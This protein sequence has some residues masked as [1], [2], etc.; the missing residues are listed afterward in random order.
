MAVFNQ[1]WT[2]MR[3]NFY[4]PAFHGVDWEASR[5]TYG[6]HVAGASTPDEMRRLMQLMIGDL[7]ASHLGV[8][9]PAARAA[10]S[11]ASACVS[12]APRMSRPAVSS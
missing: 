12:I 7:N 8:N 2:L 6:A 4:D 10:S 3:D 5:E 9:A 1:A 11:D